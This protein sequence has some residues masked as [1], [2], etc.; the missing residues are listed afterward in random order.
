MYTATHDIS[1]M[2]DL[3]VTCFELTT[4]F[5][6]T[7]KSSKLSRLP[8]LNANGD[9]IFFFSPVKYHGDT[10]IRCMNLVTEAMGLRAKYS[11]LCMQP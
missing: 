1:F 2:Y 11:Y 6:T 5:L 7:V 8:K 9:E 3:C 10:Q 4:V